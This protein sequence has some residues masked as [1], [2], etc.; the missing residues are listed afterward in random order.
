MMI[1]L[2]I[3]AGI[4]VLAGAVMGYF[5]KCSSGACPL[6]ANPFRGMIFGALIGVLFT[7]FLGYGKGASTETLAQPQPSS[8]MERPNAA[9]ETTAEEA[10]VHINN[11]DDFEKYVINAN[12]PCLVDFFSLGCPPCRILSPTIERLAEKY[13]GRA[14]VCKLSLDHAETQ[15]LARQ[16]KITAIPAVIFFN[17][18]KEV[19]RLVG[20]R[21]EEAYSKILDELIETKKQTAKEK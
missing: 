6:T 3:G 8:Q 5:G 20:L 14:M 15:E 10:V 1:R 19:D 13:K 4:G 12:R 9:K 16:Y 11:L 7:L 21:N 17:K 18:G 2:L